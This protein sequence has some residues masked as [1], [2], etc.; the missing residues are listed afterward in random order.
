MRQNKDVRLFFALWPDSALRRQ[1]QGRRFDV[2]L[3]MQLSLRASRER[4]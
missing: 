4:F 3:H 1:L 2:L